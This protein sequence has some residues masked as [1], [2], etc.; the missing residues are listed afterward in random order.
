MTLRVIDGTKDRCGGERPQGDLCRH[1]AGWG[2]DHVGFG[3]CRLHGGSTPAGRRRA[4]EEL[5][6]QMDNA[7]MSVDYLG[8]LDHCAGCGAARPKPA[9]GWRYESARAVCPRCR[10]NVRPL[11]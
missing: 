9:R 4:E 2:T 1:V 8:R 5:Q 3:E 7:A 10:A 6:E 11:P